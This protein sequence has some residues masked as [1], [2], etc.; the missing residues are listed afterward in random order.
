MVVAFLRFQSEC[1]HDIKAI[2]T[3]RT[4]P[5]PR[6]W[7][8]VSKIAHAYDRRKLKYKGDKDALAALARLELP[9]FA[10]IV[11]HGSATSFVG[12]YK[13]F[14]E[15]PDPLAIIA[16]PDTHE[17]PKNPAIKYALATTLGRTINKDNFGRI[18]RFLE[19]MGDEFN[20][21]AV[22]DALLLTGDELKA[23]KDFQ[24]WGLRHGNALLKSSR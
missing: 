17:V 18:A 20:V 21:A 3:D 15:C 22:K 6:G 14:Y 24:N 4:H 8:Q 12:Y 11:G 23:T 9:L 13:F 5:N 1:F 7:E 16:N 19:R 10:G 2:K